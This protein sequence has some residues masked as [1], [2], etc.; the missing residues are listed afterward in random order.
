MS[1]GAF[2][3]MLRVLSVL[4]AT[5][6]AVAIGGA[7]DGRSAAAGPLATAA[8]GLVVAA[9]AIALVVPSP[10]GLTVLRLLL[11][12]TV[13]GRS[14]NVGGRRCRARSVGHRGRLLRRD[15]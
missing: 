11:P 10:L 14:G 13:G 5:A 1:L 9:L 12:A 7:T 8:W 2:L 15:G 3:W 6:M 4:L